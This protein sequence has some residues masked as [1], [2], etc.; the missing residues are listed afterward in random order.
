MLKAGLM[1]PKYNYAFDGD[2]F[3][4]ISDIKPVFKNIPAFLGCFRYHDNTKGATVALSAKNKEWAEIRKRYG[5]IMSTKVPWNRQFILKKMLCRV[6]R[7]YWYTV[8]GDFDYILL[9]RA[10]NRR[11]CVEYCC[12]K[13]H[14]KF[15]LGLF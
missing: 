10:K 5:V 9:I 11:Q 13:R 15:S 12:N 4:R 6:R 2:F 1:N 7:I 14:G 3:L 8:Q